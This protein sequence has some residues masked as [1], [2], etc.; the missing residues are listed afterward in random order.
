M[1]TAK[2]AIFTP[3]YAAHIIGMRASTFMRS[4]W[5]IVGMTVVTTLACWSISSVWSLESWPRI[6]AA[7]LLVSVGYALLVYR[8]VLTNDERR[9]LAGL[10]SFMALDTGA[11]GQ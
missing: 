6:L 3:L 8:F 5:S 7:G 11:S 4:A 10:M 9:T 1:L 2:N